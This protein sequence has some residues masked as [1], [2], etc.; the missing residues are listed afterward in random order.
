[1]NHNS[2]NCTKCSHT[3]D[4]HR[5]NICYNGFCTCMTFEEAM[6]NDITI[7]LK[8]SNY[9]SIIQS[10]TS[11]P[12]SQFITTHDNWGNFGWQYKKKWGKTQS[13]MVEFLSLRCGLYQYEIREFLRCKESSVRGRLSEINNNRRRK[14]IGIHTS[15]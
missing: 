2:K 14:I 11:T 6:N 15:V 5:D 12:L 4:E 9:S 13:E 10:R 1:M 8:N 3:K 7:P